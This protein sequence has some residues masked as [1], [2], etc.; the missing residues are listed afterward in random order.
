MSAEERARSNSSMYY[1][2]GYNSGRYK[3]HAEGRDEREREILAQLT[4]R[5]EDLRSC[6]KNDDC[7]AMAQIVQVCIDDIRDTDEDDEENEHG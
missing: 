4:E 7:A 1:Y 5:A 3:G 2:T 6:G